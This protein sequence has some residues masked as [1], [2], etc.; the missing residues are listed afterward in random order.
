MATA[1]GICGCG[2]GSTGKSGGGAYA[3]NSPPPEAPA[4]IPPS[5]QEDG[6]L[7]T[8]CTLTYTGGVATGATIKLYNP[9]HAGGLHWHRPDAALCAHLTTSPAYGPLTRE[10][11][12]TSKVAPPLTVFVLYTENGSMLPVPTVV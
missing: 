1:V 6:A 4:V 11:S 9:T 10:Q 8:S 7:D 5:M 2:H 3:L 12:S